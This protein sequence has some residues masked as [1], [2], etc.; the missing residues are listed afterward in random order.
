MTESVSPVYIT[1]LLFTAN[2]HS[3]RKE[4]RIIWGQGVRSC[5][6]KMMPPSSKDVYALM[7]GACEYITLQGGTHLI[8][9]VLTI[10]EPSL[11]VV[12][13][14][15]DYGTEVREKQCGWL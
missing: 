11:V 14:R 3:F 12:N 15:F 2:L 6:R 13:G 4:G 8:T 7:H 1:Y 5:G 10:R 9:R